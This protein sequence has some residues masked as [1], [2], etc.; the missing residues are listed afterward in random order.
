MLILKRE[1]TI[2]SIF[3]K[4]N[5]Q[6]HELLRDVFILHQKLLLKYL[7][8]IHIQWGRLII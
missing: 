2:R 1:Y 3:Q 4:M 7:L 6:T 5:K 8:V